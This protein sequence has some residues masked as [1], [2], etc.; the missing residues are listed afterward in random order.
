MELR[1]VYELFS[2]LMPYDE[3]REFT[4]PNNAVCQLLQAHFVSM[5]LIM[6]PITRNEWEGR[7]NSTADNEDGKTGHWLKAIHKSIPKGM[8][9]YYEWTLWVEREVYE[10]GRLMNGDYGGVNVSVE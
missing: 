4:D 6:T 7:K 9:P 1:K 5:Q 8:E 2:Y 10:R 3:F